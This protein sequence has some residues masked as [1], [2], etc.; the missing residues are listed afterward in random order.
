MSVQCRWSHETHLAA[1]AISASQSR[2]F[3]SRHL[4]AHDLVDIVDEVQLVVS[5]LST[6]AILHAQ[7]PF[8]LSLRAFDA[9]LRLEVADESN[10]VPSLVVTGSLDTYG[11]GMALV[12]ALSRDWGVEHRTSDGKSVWAE[13]DIPR[14]YTPAL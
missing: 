9:T 6:N 7:T 14:T 12:Q 11:R 10:H 5:E 13:F 1:Q 8:T 3:A 2:V 4:L